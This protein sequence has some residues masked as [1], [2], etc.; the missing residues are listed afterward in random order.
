MPMSGFGGAYAS[1]WRTPNFVSYQA[2]AASS[3]PDRPVQAAPGS[4]IPS[5]LPPRVPPGTVRERNARVIR[6]RDALWVLTSVYGM[7]SVPS[8]WRM[9]STAGVPSVTTSTLRFT[10]PCGAAGDGDAVTVDAAV[11]LGAGV[12]AG[13]GVP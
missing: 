7:P 3:D 1:T 12:L 9:A 2:S 13:F 10:P 11:G 4:T 6:C 5:K 8:C